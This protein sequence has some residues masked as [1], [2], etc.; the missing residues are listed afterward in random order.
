MIQRDINQRR[1]TD[2]NS[3]KAAIALKQSKIKELRQYTTRV[4]VNVR[5]QS[6]PYRTF[7]VPYTATAK[8]KP[9]ARRPKPQRPT[10]R[11][12]SVQSK[13]MAQRNRLRQSRQAPAPRKSISKVT[14]RKSKLVPANRMRM[15]RQ[16]RQQRAKKR[17]RA[18]R[19]MGPTRSK[20]NRKA[21]AID[22][23]RSRPIPRTKMRRNRRANIALN[24]DR[25]S[26]QQKS[27]SDRQKAFIAQQK[28]LRAIQA[29][30]KQEKRS[31]RNQARG[32]AQRAGRR[33]AKSRAVKAAS[34]SS[35]GRRLSKV[36]SNKSRVAQKRKRAKGRTRS[37]RNRLRFGQ[38]NLG[39]VR[40]NE[41]LGQAMVDLQQE[42]SQA[43]HEEN[44]LTAL[45][46][47]LAK[48][49]AT[50]VQQLYAEEEDFAGTAPRH[51][52]ITREPQSSSGKSFYDNREFNTYASRLAL[53]SGG[54]PT[55]AYKELVRTYNN[56][57]TNG[58]FKSV[59]QALLSFTQQ[60]ASK[61][62]EYFTRVVTPKEKVQARQLG[63][64]TVQKNRMA[65]STPHV[66]TITARQR[67][68]YE[69][70][71]VAEDARTKAA[72]KSAK[73]E[74]QLAGVFPR[75]RSAM[76]RMTR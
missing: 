24:K 59:R 69:Q 65:K 2:V 4:P 34:K 66:R 9:K 36:R 26:S 20:G 67:A 8:I 43:Q 33:V 53:D 56:N 6:N 49:E 17:F 51:A 46:G 25:N 29:R 3:A 64:L 40:R 27:V 52:R 70:Q 39:S 63:I 12:S 61:R 74:Q 30:R 73:V 45:F 28:R 41:G 71:R 58:Q 22:R 76:E 7:N 35:I 50:L 37:L 44:Q 54:V 60:V 42:L 16:L 10:P 32:R 5:S 72:D 14:K 11:K 47:Q 38:A 1:I 57:I 31:V 62:G 48:E 55:P 15:A 23:A 21:K 13:M 19:A 68:L 75:T 18:R